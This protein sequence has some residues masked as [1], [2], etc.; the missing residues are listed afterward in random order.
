MGK[1]GGDQALNLGP[2]GKLQEH[3]T[4]LSAALRCC[5]SL[6]VPIAQTWNSYPPSSC[7]G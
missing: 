4:F 3:E 7:P 6:N 5:P 1:T 2:G